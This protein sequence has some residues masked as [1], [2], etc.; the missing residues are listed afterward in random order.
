MQYVPYCSACFCFTSLWAACIQAYAQAYASVVKVNMLTVIMT[1]PPTDLDELFSTPIPTTVHALLGAGGCLANMEAISI[2]L[3]DTLCTL[4]MRTPRQPGTPSEESSL[5]LNTSGLDPLQHYTLQHR[6]PMEVK[7]L[8][9]ADSVRWLLQ[10][11]NMQFWFFGRCRVF[12][13]V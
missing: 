11:T 6:E 1:T 2:P 5:W 9:Q 4:C 13:K 10:W 8:V 12:W 7:L 3:Y